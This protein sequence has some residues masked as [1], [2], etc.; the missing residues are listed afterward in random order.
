MLFINHMANA[1]AA[2]DYFTEHLSPGDYHS[3]D[4]AEMRGEWHGRGA[5]MLH[6]SGEVSREDFFRLCENTN[7]ETGGQLTPRMK[8][9]RRVLTDFTFDVPKSVSLAYELGGADGKGDGRVLPAMRESVRETMAEMESA[10][11]GRVRKAGADT[12]RPTGNMIWA[13]HIHRTTRPV[14]GLPD[15]QLHCHATVFNATFDDVEGRWKAIQ[16][17]DIVRDKGYYQSAFHARLAGKLSALGYGI[18]KDG[19]SFSLAGIDRVTIEKFSRRTAV[20]EAEAERLGID[21]AKSKGEL[22]RKTREKKNKDRVGMSEL[23]TEWD[24]RLTPEEQLAIRTAASGR[25]RGDDAITPQ[26]AKEYALEHSFEN[27]STVSEKRLKAEALTYAVGSIRPEDVADITQQP[28]VIAE[29]RG[30]QLMTTTRTVLRDE[31]SM[32]QFAKDGQ[33][34]QQPFVRKLEDNA[35]A[36]LTDEQ[37]KA[38]LHVLKS[39]DTVTGIV[40]KAGTGKTRMIRA[41]IDALQ[42]EAS[43]KVFVFAPSS[44]ASRGVLKNEGFKDAET[45]EMLLRN[46]KLQEKTKGQVLWIDEA[47]LVS[48]KDMRRLMDL[49]K[50]NGNR[51]ILSGDYTQHSSVEAGDAFR[52]LEKEA[53]VRLARLAEIRRQTDPGYR[54]AVEAISQ[55]TGKAAQ[56]GFDAL[57]RMGSIV[58]A[59]G[60]ERHSLLVA[61]YLNAVED[62]KSALIIAPTHA[63]G[64]R[65]TDELRRALKERGAI[66]KERQFIARRATGWTQAQKGD[67]RNYEPGMVVEFHQN[68]KGFTRGDKAAVKHGAGGL[69]LQKQ[70]GTEAALPLAQTDRFEVYRTREIAL[71]KGDRIRITKNGE[72][73]VE[74]Q[75]KGTRLSNGDI[76]TV[77]GFSKEGDIRIEKGK[78]LP[79]DWGHMSLGYVDT[80]Y[81]SQGK[82]VDRV[83]IATGNESLPATNQQQWYVS[84]SRGREMAKVYVEDKQEVRDAIARTGQRLSAVE[85]THTR[86]KDS[87]GARFARSFERHRVGRFLKQRAEVIADYWRGREG[88]RYA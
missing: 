11:Q 4:A 2:K 46:E 56:K 48:S 80:S 57:D 62:G 9:D 75:A 34:K 20:I 64:Q 6:L 69:V 58:E 3:K 22:G 21:N 53:G 38:A 27:A 7:P 68:A 32:L 15:P 30:G 74:G 60:E 24:S 87:W 76:L 35:L 39:R 73:K 8:D 44:Q 85:L 82:T 1:K 78:L 47:G 67:I 13:E 55:G 31:I 33:R 66:G 84:A 19:N 5:E 70:D 50:R 51:V 36:G 52:L 79:K 49:A 61:D 43:Q 63:E 65:L 59:T 37:K 83:F 10:A 77:E 16:L 54:K 40:G 41:T 26:Q 72:A 86:L 12:D 23:R 81:S 71:A 25:A 42:S 28:G 88:V 14:D 45:L 29:T 17:G 18:Q